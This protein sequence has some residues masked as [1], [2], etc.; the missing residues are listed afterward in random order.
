VHDIVCGGARVDLQ[1][2][3]EVSWAEIDSL[4]DEKRADLLTQA[5]I[6]KANDLTRWQ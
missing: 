5:D 4:T 2:A 3:R 6:R 1:L